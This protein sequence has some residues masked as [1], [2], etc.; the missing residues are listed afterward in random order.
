V[1]KTND[2]GHKTGVIRYII[3]EWDNKGTSDFS[4]A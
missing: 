1:Q 3:S 2:P 4:A